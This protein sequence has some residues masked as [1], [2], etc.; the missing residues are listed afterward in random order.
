MV[1]FNQIRFGL[2]AASFALL[3]ACGSGAAPETPVAA[4]TAGAAGSSA[5][6]PGSQAGAAGQGQAGSGIPVGPSANE[7]CKAKADAGE[8]CETEGKACGTQYRC[9]ANMVVHKDDV[10]CQPGDVGQAGSDQGQAGSDAGQA[11]SATVP[12][13][14]CKTYGAACTGIGK[15]CPASILACCVS[16]KMGDKDAATCM[17]PKGDAGAAGQGQAGNGVSGAGTGGSDAA[18]TGGA[19]QSGAG[20]SAAGTGGSAGNGGSSGTGG[21]GGSAGAGGSTSGTGGSSSGSGGST[22]AGAGG[23]AA[24]NGGSSG[25]STAGA[26]QGGAGQGGTGGQPAM[27]VIDEVRIHVRAVKN[28]PLGIFGQAEPKPGSASKDAIGPSWTGSPNATNT[29]PNGIDWEIQIERDAVLSMNGQ[30][31]GSWDF[32]FCRYGKATVALWAE[33]KDGTPL[34]PFTIK[35]MGDQWGSCRLEIE[36]RKAPVSAN[37]ADG[38]GHVAKAAGGDDCNDSPSLGGHAV[39]PGQIESFG[40]DINGNAMDLDC[41]GSADPQVTVIVMAGPGSWTT[42]EPA[43]IVPMACGLNPVLRDVDK[44]DAAHT[45]AMVEKPV[46]GGCIYHTFK[47]GAGAI[48]IDQRPAKFTVSWS[49]DTGW[50]SQSWKGYCE[51]NAAFQGIY[52]PLGT[53]A[54]TSISMLGMVEKCVFGATYL[55]N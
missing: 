15:V 24:G 22:A 35:N 34:P 49:N 14:D 45:Y 47:E 48:P 51:A 43:K 28:V 55:Y 18:G 30:H 19:G 16:G 12:E 2:V 32:P 46:T 25:S 42:A 53:P 21:A 3:T 29:V 17:P 54:T 1:S 7:V 10:L 37:D 44:W 23:S 27:V 4:P 5:L 36:N 8:Y 38:D 52:A 26:P 6:P 40:A 41:D 39:H 13:L 50:S 31:N 11:G 9:C 33:R 20:G